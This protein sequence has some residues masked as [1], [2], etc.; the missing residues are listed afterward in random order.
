[1]ADLSTFQNLPNE[2]LLIIVEFLTSVA[3]FNIGNLNT[4]LHTIL[5]STFYKLALQERLRILDLRDP[6]YYAC[7]TCLHLKIPDAFS[8]DQMQGILK[9]NSAFLVRES[10]QRQCLSCALNDPISTPGTV[11]TF[12]SDDRKRIVCVFCWTY[13]ET[14]FLDYLNCRIC[15]VEYRP[16][17]WQFS[18]TLCLTNTEECVEAA[19]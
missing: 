10:Y 15:D 18:P 8:A 14:W 12:K 17:D 19:S 5:C 6:Y 16:L 13:H 7:C 2:I 1:M 9:R 11:V 3:A 4:R